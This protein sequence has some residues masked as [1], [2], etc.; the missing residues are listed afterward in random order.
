MGSAEATSDETRSGSS[1]EKPT[2]PG[3]VQVFSGGQPAFCP[4]PIGSG[5]VV[6][7]ATGGGFDVDDD[8]LSRR[9]FRVDSHERG[10]F[11]V[12]DEGSRNG[13]WVDGVRGDRSGAKSGAV[14]RA[15]RSVFLLTDD[16]R[17][18]AEA[19]SSGGD[20]VCGPTLRGALRRIERLAPH[21]RTLAVHGESG[22]GKELAARR[23]HEAGGGGPF[24]A[25]NCA[26]IP[27]GMAERL[28]FGTKRGAYSGAQA[29]AQG[30][31]ATADG[32]TL[33]LDEIAE[34]DVRV[35][36]KLLRVLE[37]GEFVPLG[38][39]RATTAVF[40]LCVATHKNLRDEV[41]QGRFRADLYYRLGIDTVELPPLRDRRED[42]PVFVVREAAQATPALEVDA[43]LVDACMR[44]AWPGNVRE[45]VAEIRRALRE[46]AA[47][48]RDVVDERA[49]SPHAGVR[50][51]EAGDAS[52]PAEGGT[53]RDWPSDDLIEEKLRAT[54]G[55]V[56]RAARELGVHRNQLRRW[57]ARRTDG[58]ALT[59]S[60]EADAP[61][62]SDPES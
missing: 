57:L 11:V 13:T 39:A 8:R 24:V 42:I 20:L 41:A 45:L 43:S 48:G 9:H 49:L 50:L 51:T 47:A 16:I 52:S 37:S 46:T 33:F 6:G 55:N 23:F 30:W 28:L 5:L 38:A 61:H 25:V 17:P 19:P 58:E 59:A 1:D 62:D 32:G 35:Q 15:G 4:R 21:A 7:R 22:S 26:T 27:E 18:F 14:I 56:T 12:V 2:L 60:P 31:V 53:G 44:R 3:I 34:L 29:D 10:V 40:R 36:A 54:Q